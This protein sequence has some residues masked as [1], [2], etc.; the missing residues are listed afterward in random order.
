MS[1]P[2][3]RLDLLIY[4]YETITTAVISARLSIQVTINVQL[5]VSLPLESRQ[6][7]LSQRGAPD[8]FQHSTR[9][10]VTSVAYANGRGFQ[11]AHH[12]EQG[13]L[14]RR[15][16]FEELFHTSTLELKED[17]A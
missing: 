16:N 3:S 6:R 15:L 10:S 13:L 11:G 2:G 8:H 17:T 5:R 12:Q 1:N 7:T 4:I 9:K 14:K